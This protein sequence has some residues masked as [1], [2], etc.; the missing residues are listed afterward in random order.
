M[1]LYILPLSDSQA[2]IETVGGKGMSLSRLAQMGLP[3]PAGFHVTTEAYRQFVAANAL[4]GQILSALQSADISQPATLETASA[5]ISVLFTE[6]QIPSDVEAAIRNTYEALEERKAVAVR[7]SATAEDLPDASFAGQQET[8]LNIR[9]TDAVLEGV[10]KCW[11][12]LWTA[13]AI[14]YRIKN[15][16]DQN[17]VALAVVVQELV[18]AEAAGIMF[19]A[20][21]LNGQRNELVINAAWG[22]GEA[23][24]ASAVT[25][26]TLIV[27]KQKGKVIQREIADKLV[28]TVR[29]EHGTSEVP[30]PDAKKK[31][32]VLSDA[33]AMELARLG[34]RIE[35]IYGMPMDIEWTFAE[36]KF[37]IVQ[38]RPITALPPEWTRPDK[39][40]VYGRGSLAEHTPSPVTPLF[41][42][43]GLGI[44]NEASAEL[45]KR[46]AGQG[47]EIM[48]TDQGAYVVLNG[49]VYGGYRMD[50]RAMGVILKVSLSQLA[51]M[52]RGSVARWQAAR[53]ELA[54]VVEAWQ[55][56][57]IESLSPS[58]L[59]EGV[60]TVFGAAC[61]YFTSIQ[62]TLPAASMS[63]IFFTR[64]YSK[65]IKRKEDPEATVFLL[66]S[67][68]VAI[69]AEKSLFDI[70]TWMKS[71]PALAD[72]ALHTQT[73]QLLADLSQGTPPS[74]IPA[75]LWAEWRSVFQRH[76]DTFGHTA[77]EFDFANPTPAETPGPLLD[78]IKV[79]LEGK[80]QNPYERQRESIEKRE[81]ATQSILKRVG[82]PRR[83]WFEKLLR[84]AQE[85]GPMRENSIFDMGMGHPLIRR[86][87]AELGH[88]F[89]AGGAIGSADDI[90]WLEKSEVDEL[91]AALEAGEPLP[92]FAGR[93]P[94]RKA[95]WQSFLKITP[96]VM[97]PEKT[98]WN[99]FVHGDEAEKKDG[100][101]ILKGV[102]T[103]SG[104]ITA[105]ARV[106]I[107]PE[108]FATMKPGE[109]LV[110]VTTTP[111]WTP[112]F[113]MASAV[114][115][116]IGG[117]LSHSSIVAREYG[118]PAVMA[119]RNA[120][121]HIQNG[122]LVTVDGTAGTVVLES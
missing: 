31:K 71:N 25:P 66:G 1:K 118:I 41:A 24:V 46:V 8:Y 33:Q 38:A 78:A 16:I 55:Q 77:Y 6:S 14:A 18:F 74:S 52:F 99:K 51:P 92:N 40:A 5:T 22:L 42:T 68:T 39:A 49:Y 50:A 86:M 10:K 102:G 82:W 3:V 108:D 115:T 93:V 37:A 11:A 76:L 112:L 83:G 9:G 88:R 63:E 47:A 113:A 26:D 87:F 119:A 59:L 81:R 13:R 35:E 101:L 17:S 80:A 20:N 54:A 34:V 2:D 72:Y 85:T 23:I 106:L 95:E 7:S 70:A 19:T 67:E 58:E 4:Q 65:L 117:P 97:L 121:R 61:R 36:N 94:A 28:M 96:P 105:P 89:V 62:T 116:D 120:T 15:K 43:L 30:V 32:A 53:K 12:S 84:W 75:D 27:D 90:Y 111:A 64:L 107:G 48:Q 73:N 104:T 103:S 69:Q 79:F 29:T 114:V 45:L 122:Q 21:P 44:A 91:V 110:A 98:R 56:R 109:V 57:P 100:K 60:R